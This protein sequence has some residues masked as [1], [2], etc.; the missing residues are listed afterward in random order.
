MNPKKLCRA[1]MRSDREDKIVE[2]LS[3][4]GYWTK[5][6]VWRYLGDNDNNYSGIG[7]QQSESV[8]ALTEKLINSVDARLMNECL[9]S[10][11]Q[12]TASD[13]PK[14]MRDAVGRFFEGHRGRL[15]TE[16]GVIA[17]WPDAKMTEEAKR[18]TLA[19]T[20]F[21]P[22]SGSG[23]MCL[24]VAD[25][26][27]GQTPDEFPATFLS[28]HKSNKL[29]VPFV[30]GK[31]N[32]GGTGAL[33]FCSPNHNLQLIVSRRNPALTTGGGREQEWGFTV[34]RRESPSGGTRSSVFTYLAPLDIR[35]GRDG[36]VLS[37]SSDTWPIFPKVDAKG[38]DAY[39]RDARYGSL[40]KLYEYNLS[41]SRSR[42]LGTKGGLLQ[43]VDFALPELALPIRLYECRPTYRG[44]LGSFST[45]VLGVV[46]RLERD[47]ADKLEQGFPIGHLLRLEG[48]EVRVRAYALKGS[49]QVYRSGRNAIA[50]S[51][52][53]QTHATMETNF[54]RRKSVGLS[55]LADSL[56]VIVDCSDIDGRLR[57]DMFM[58]SRD[59]LY[60][61]PETQQLEAG[62]ERFLKDDP[63][64]RELKNR[65]REKEIRERLAEARPL[66]EALSNL[67]Q[68]NPS[69]SRLLGGGSAIPSPFPKSGTE[70][71]GGRV[72][73]L[74]KRFPTFFRFRKRAD[75]E[76]LERAAHLESTV[77][78]KF[79][80]D[81]QDDY[82]HRDAERGEFKVY[83]FDNIN[84]Y[85]KLLSNYSLNGP[86][87][88]VARLSFDLPDSCTVGERVRVQIR[89]TD[90][91]RIDPFNLE[92]ILNVASP[93]HH[94]AGTTGKDRAPNSGV[95]H[96]GKASALA[97]PNVV[98]VHQS[99][100][101]VHK[102]DELSALRVVDQ[103]VS[104]SGQEEYDFFVNYDN[105]HLL[106]AQKDP[107]R[108]SETLRAQFVYSLVL[109]SMALLIEEKSKGTAAADEAA[110]L[111]PE[112][113]IRLVSRRLASFVL[114]TIEAMGALVE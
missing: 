75:G 8:A 31:F 77:R 69:L 56:I 3:E 96:D 53:G 106:V 64:L 33:K 101:E 58:N 35:N 67:V 30:Q 114:P 68:R 43:R 111:N 48:R 45:N 108:D 85:W 50:F 65:R 97:L 44:H 105:K 52:N 10:G 82:F 15:P 4:S 72:A 51:I 25:A 37:F 41:G 16:A 9:Q 42:I 14:A 84:D 63:N 22:S 89:V 95:G 91:S 34:V 1:L 49:A 70:R 80:T 5:P 27:E 76:N 54:F 40:V 78:L 26:G 38:R 94:S 109:Y 13:A 86:T 32:M 7:N 46:A 11:I 39:G 92:A 47:R 21:G 28:L 74:G 104:N 71:G 18:L 98:P 73:F 19:A 62:L 110:G 55:Q 24:T 59:R 102:F 81:A 23:L 90:P 103:G 79:E 29:R 107:S 2:L 112:D 99:D 100:W 20:G 57:E 93:A 60:R 61:T 88:G 36:S 87:S 17:L 12:P 83:L 113:L 66:A 6:A